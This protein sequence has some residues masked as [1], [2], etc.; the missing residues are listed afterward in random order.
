MIVDRFYIE[1]LGLDP[2][3]PAWERIGRDWIRPADPQARAQLYRQL[4]HNA[5]VTHA[6]G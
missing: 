3:D 1:S 2:D 6:L 4:V 5:L